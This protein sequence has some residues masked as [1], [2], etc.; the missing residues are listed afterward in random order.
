MTPLLQQEGK[1][2]LFNMGVNWLSLI[3]VIH[4]A[5]NLVNLKGIFFLIKNKYIYF[6]K[7]A[8]YE[9]SLRKV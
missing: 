2:D 9:L 7:G 8:V 4:G 3:S 1:L 6:L 5:V